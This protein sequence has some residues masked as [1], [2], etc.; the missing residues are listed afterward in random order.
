MRPAWGCQWEQ[1]FKIKKNLNL[2]LVTANLN[3]SIRLKGIIPST[4]PSLLPFLLF[5]DLGGLTEILLHLY[6]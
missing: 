3:P 6:A 4:A 1:W 5:L 2:Q